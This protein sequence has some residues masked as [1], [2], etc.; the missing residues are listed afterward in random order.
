MTVLTALSSTTGLTATYNERL[1]IVFGLLTLASGLL[2]FLTCRICV[3][4]LGRL[5]WKNPVRSKM[6]GFFYRYH[7]YYWWTFGVLL[8]AH[9]MVAVLHTG[10]AQGGNPDAGTHW[11]ILGLGLFGAFSSASL[12]FS[13]RVLPRLIALATPK[14]P[15]NNPI[16]SGFYRYHAYYWLAL[17]LLV[18]AHFAVSYNHAGTWP[19]G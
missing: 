16:F 9:F 5:G 13:C 4:L 1:A 11:A 14:E 18:A 8:V 15:L 6:Y 19:P 10:L 3:G 7:I 12:F 17:A 2:V